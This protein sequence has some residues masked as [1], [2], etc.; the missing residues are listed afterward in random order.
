MGKE[1]KKFYGIVLVLLLL[2]IVI[3]VMN[4][5]P[6]DSSIVQER[7]VDQYSDMFF[8]YTIVRYPAKTEIL[9]PTQITENLTIGFNT[10]TSE[11]DFGRVEAGGSV[12]KWINLTTLDGRPSKITVKSKG[13]IGP[14]LSFGRD[15]FLLNG[16]GSISV[17]MSATQPGNYTGEVSVFVQRSNY[18]LLRLFLGY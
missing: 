6:E 9:A 18:D 12:K 1:R 11:L 14:L 10:G 15:D 5:R 7:T 4:T 3:T 2:G 8:T 13:I 16:G 17:T